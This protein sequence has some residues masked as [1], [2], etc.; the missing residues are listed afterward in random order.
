M[1][2]TVLEAIA[3]GLPIV[4][5]VTGGTEELVTNGENGFFVEKESPEDLAEK[6]GKLASDAGLRARMGAASRIKAESMSWKKVAEQ[7][8][9]EYGRSMN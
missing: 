1:S 2:N 3:S 5:T 7:Y 9:A 8:V 4:A 6:I